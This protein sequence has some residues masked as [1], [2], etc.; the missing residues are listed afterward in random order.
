MLEKREFTKFHLVM[1]IAVIIGVLTIAWA[2]IS[3][4]NI[5]QKEKEAQHKV[6]V[7]EPVEVIDEN[8]EEPELPE[9]MKE[10]DL[11]LREYNIE[12]YKIESG[13]IGRYNTE[14]LN[15]LINSMVN[16]QDENGNKVELKIST[17][18]SLTD[19][20]ITDDMYEE[21]LSV[22]QPKNDCVIVLVRSNLDNLS[23]VTSKLR[24]YFSFLERSAS[25]NKT[26]NTFRYFETFS[27]NSYSV[28]LACDNAMD[29]SAAV[30]EYM[31]NLDNK[32]VK[33]F[34]D[35]YELTE[36]G[37]YLKETEEETEETEPIEETYGEI[38]GSVIKTP[39]LDD[40]DDF[41]YGET[42]SDKTEVSS[43]EIENTEETEVSSEEI[44]NNEE[45]VSEE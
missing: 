24:D 33:E 2:S 11:T 7:T 14:E 18:N 36:Y 45:I 40:Y 23:A 29:L 8:I 15:Q 25:N 35:L 19:A 9:D 20:L 4:Y 3:I 34:E 10:P 37:A 31:V 16:V 21:C 39:L 17:D 28:F 26:I 6:E 32:A 1:I 13:N 12:K 43:E 42:S 22:W 41:L 38:Q 27:Y 30:Q 44:E 5:K